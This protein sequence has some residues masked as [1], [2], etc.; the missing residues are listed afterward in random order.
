MCADSS[1]DKKFNKKI[2]IMCHVSGDI[3]Q[4]SHVRCHL[5]IIWHH[6]TRENYTSTFICLTD[7]VKPGMFFRA[8]SLPNRNWLILRSC[9][10][11]RPVS[12]EG[13]VLQLTALQCTAPYCIR[14][15]CT[16]LHCTVLHITALHC[17]AL[18]CTA[19]YCTLLHYT[20]LHLTALHS[21]A[22]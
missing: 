15:Y 19:L 11:S 7:P 1:T 8:L 18:Y 2:R 21:T 9:G 4:V 13:G 14:L 17:I 6:S 20:L 10:L 5:S 12:W 16:L 22:P 3:C